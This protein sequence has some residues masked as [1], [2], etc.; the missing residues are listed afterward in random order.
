MH[1]SGVN[2]PSRFAI[3]FRRFMHLTAAKNRFKSAVSLASISR[4]TS[5][6]NCYTVTFLFNF[7]SYFCL[8]VSVE[9]FLVSWMNFQLNGW[10]T[11]TF[12]M[13]FP[14]QTRQVRMVTP[15]EW[16][17]TSQLA[18]LFTELQDSWQVML[19][20]VQLVT[21]WPC[22]IPIF[23]ET[24]ILN[25]NPT[26]TLASICV[27]YLVIACWIVLNSSIFIRSISISWCRLIQ[28]QRA[29]VVF[30]RQKQV[31]MMKETL[32]PCATLFRRKKQSSSH[33]FPKET[34]EVEVV[35]QL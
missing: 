24:V 1:C 3:S 5:W 35:L 11:C 18:L 23:C 16:F 10:E 14:G 25:R 4:V 27:W 6:I 15:L 7:I 17:M 8:M 20:L 31:W 32:V 26:L 12:Y 30:P 22:G 29:L 13:Q 28:T 21:H 2:D 9:V 19:H 34:T 33:S